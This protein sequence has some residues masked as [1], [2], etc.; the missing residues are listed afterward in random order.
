MA[1]GRGETWG[2]MGSG[3]GTDDLADW[4]CLAESEWLDLEDHD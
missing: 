3:Q 2:G 4:L 1:P